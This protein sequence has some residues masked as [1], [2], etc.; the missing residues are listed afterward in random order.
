MTKKH[1]ILAAAAAAAAFFG[2]EALS[3][4]SPAKPATKPATPQA[5]A[6]PIVVAPSAPHPAATPDPTWDPNDP[7]QRLQ[8]PNGSD[9]VDNPAGYGPSAANTTIGQGGANPT[10]LAGLG[11]TTGQT[12][13]GEG[14][15]ADW[16]SPPGPSDWGI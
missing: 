7:N 10:T 8:D 9:W 15:Q 11:D 12:A 3:K 1:W 6:P 4:A 13:S 16:S 14:E 2:W 5:K